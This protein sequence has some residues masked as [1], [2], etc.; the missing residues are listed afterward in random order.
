ML[1]SHRTHAAA[2]IFLS[3]ASATNDAIQLNI[4]SAP[5]PG[6]NTLVGNFQG[7]SMEMADFDKIAGNLSYSSP[8]SK[9][10]FI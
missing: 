2:C 3:A 9:S 1:F 7:F 8:A 10:L 6:S 5:A 4:P